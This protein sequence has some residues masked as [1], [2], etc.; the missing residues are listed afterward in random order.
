MPWTRF[1]MKMT[2]DDVVQ[3]LVLV[4]DIKK[5]IKSAEEWDT[6]SHE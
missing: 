4:V 1:R 6:V 2:L 3:R 5:R